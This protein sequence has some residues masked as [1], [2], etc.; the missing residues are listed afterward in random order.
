VRDSEVTP[1]P[2]PAPGFTLAPGLIREVVQGIDFDR[3]RSVHK[4]W[5]A[6]LRLHL[7]SNC[8]FRWPASSLDIR[9]WLAT[10]FELL[11]EEIDSLRYTDPYFLARLCHLDSTRAHALLLKEVEEVRAALDGRAKGPREEALLKALATFDAIKPAS[12]ETPSDTPGPPEES[13]SEKR[14]RLVAQHL[15]CQPKAKSL[16]IA[17]AIGCN[18]STVR[19]TIAWKKRPGA[20]KRGRASRRPREVPLTDQM[21]ACRGTEADP[22]EEAADREVLERKFLEG[23]TDDEKARYFNMRPADR[24]DALRAFCEQEDERKQEERR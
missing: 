22:S 16:E 18:E 7:E 3:L 24:A 2:R 14:D 21:M 23:A 4:V 8:G 12:V 1:E 5:V 13:A 17:E 10:R 15:A 20:A 11:D 9:L 19:K 6:P